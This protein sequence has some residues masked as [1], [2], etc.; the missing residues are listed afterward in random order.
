MICRKPNPL[1]PKPFDCDGRLG[2]RNLGASY[3]YLGMLR[4]MQGDARSAVN[5]LD[6]AVEIAS[7]GVHSRCCCVLLASE[8]QIGH[9]GH[10][11][12][13]G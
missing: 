13:A 1:L 6:R 10:T 3:A 8:G 11:R 9:I 7:T 2:N 4:L 5:L 12:G